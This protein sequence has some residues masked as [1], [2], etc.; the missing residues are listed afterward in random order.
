MFSSDAVTF[1]EMK[2][3]PFETG[4][5]PHTMP[6]NHPPLQIR[7]INSNRWYLRWYQGVVFFHENELKCLLPGCSANSLGWSA[8]DVAGGTIENEYHFFI[9]LINTS[10]VCGYR[11]FFFHGCIVVVFEASGQ[12]KRSLARGKSFTNDQMSLI[13]LNSAFLMRPVGVLGWWR[14]QGAE[15]RGGI[16]GLCLKM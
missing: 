8:H 9:Y 13:S 4:Y 14:W 2:G 1:P 5:S 12:Q 10:L 3:K 11:F 15:G 7:R 6:L 16:D